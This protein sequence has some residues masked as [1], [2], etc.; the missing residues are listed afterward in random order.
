[1]RVLIGCESS[2]RERDAFIAL[3]HEA[4][5]CDLKPTERPGPHY[6]GDL[7]DLIDYPWDMVIFHIP[8]TDTANSGAKH[9]P[10]K[11]TNGKHYANVSLW[12]R[13]ER[14]SR[15][16]PKRAFEHPMSVMSTL[17]RKRDQE[18]QPWQF[19]NGEGEEPGRGE[20][21]TT[22]LWLDGLPLLVPTTPHETGRIQA[23]WR[24]GPSETRAEDRARAYTG[25]CRAMAEQWGRSQLSFEVAA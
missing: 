25:I 24:M 8:C 12:M 18:I 4:I 10:A 20:V 5:S 14:N 21:K 15:H 3:G 7:F 17:W 23:C 1:M 9:F 16:I 13:A 2:G 11:R 22:W 19:W 6:Q